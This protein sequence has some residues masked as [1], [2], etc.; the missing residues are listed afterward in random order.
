MRRAIAYILTVMLWMTASDARAQFDRD[1]KIFVVPF[2]HVD[3]G[4]TEPVPEVIEKQSAFID[5]AIAFVERTASHPPESRFKWTIEIAWPL[6]DYLQ[7]R[8][9]EQINRLMDHVRSGSIEIGAMHFSLQTDLTGPEELVRSLYFGRQI[10]TLYDVDIRTA[11]T[12]DTPG[13]TWS[14]AQLLNRAEIPYFS[15]AMNSF[16]SDFYKTTELPNLFYWEGQSGDRTLVWRSIHEQWAYLEGITWGVYHSYTLMNQ[17][18]TALLNSLAAEGYPYD[19]VLINAATGDNG[20]PRINIAHIAKEWNEEH[21]DSEVRVATFEEFFDY[22]ASADV[23]IP[24]F[25]GD[26]PNWWTWS[27]AS[28]ATGGHL[29]SKRAQVKLPA[30]EAAAS[31]ARLVEPSYNYPAEDLRRAYVD[32]LLFEDHNLGAATNRPPN[33]NAEFWELKMDWVNGA[34]DTAESVKSSALDSWASSVGSEDPHSAVVFNLTPWSRSDVARIDAGALAEHGFGDVVITDVVTGQQVEQQKLS[35]G[36]VVFVADSVP[37]FG[38][39]RFRIEPGPPAGTPPQLERPVLENDLYRIEIDGSSGGI[40]SLLDKELNLDLAMG[41]GRFA[42]YVLNGSGLPQVS[43]IESDSGA[44][45]QRL[46]L[47]GSAPGSSAYQTEIILYEH[48]R[49]IDVIP[50][51][52][53][54]LPTST[55]NVDFRFN[56]A[57]TNSSLAYEIPFGRVRIFEDELSGFKSNHYAWLRW[58]EIS[59]AEVTTVLATTGAGVHAQ[60]SGSF[61]G[62][63]RLLTSFNNP[64]TAYRAGVGPL[65]TGFSITTRDPG[66]DPLASTRFAYGFNHPF[67]TRL[68]ESSDGQIDEPVY[69]FLRFE[70]DDIFVST[71]KQAED[72]R[73]YILRV[74][75]P[76]D[77]TSSTT[78]RSAMEIHVRDDAARGRSWRSRCFRWRA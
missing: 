72:G 41:D 61:D 66:H 65:S 49:R 3:V 1:W 15:L 47:S 27:F 13:F 56:F 8:P 52:D 16:L 53:K 37:S 2:S 58:S 4:F 54:D 19:F 68:V 14:L 73:G 22:A 74:F 31:I 60:S 7:T 78:I 40:T 33:E 45:M 18:V 59:S 26:A 69:S 50:R 17:R 43:V 76:S 38:F 9:T 24:V 71:F 28:S 32:N 42:Q 63:A 23:D 62:N 12:N 46:V 64:G 20:A 29:Q 30:A 55:E 25:S 39:R 48:E 57:L 34:V 36:E 5:S 35:S 75:N 67:E 21:T 44:V 6:E 10:E 70:G 11:I 51:W 77:M